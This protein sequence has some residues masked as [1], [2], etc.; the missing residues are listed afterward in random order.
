MVRCLPGSECWF[1]CELK[2]EADSYERMKDAWGQLDEEIE[3]ALKVAGW[4]PGTFEWE[5]GPIFKENRRD[6]LLVT[7]IKRLDHRPR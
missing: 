6:M 7:Q 3:A 1:Y 5:S 2:D 4:M